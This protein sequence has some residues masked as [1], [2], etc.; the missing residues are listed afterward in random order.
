MDIIR[1]YLLPLS[2]AFELSNQ[3]YDCPGY[4]TELH[5]V[6]RLQFWSSGEFGVVFVAIV[7]RYTLKPFNCANK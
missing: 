3:K 4:D 1:Y 7:P 6:V 5:P 2:S